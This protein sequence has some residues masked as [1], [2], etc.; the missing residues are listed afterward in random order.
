MADAKKGCGGGCGV[1]PETA[2]A[3]KRDAQSHQQSAT[4]RAPEQPTA[5]GAHGRTL[6]IN[7]GP[8][9]SAECE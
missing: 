3:A 1:G 9:C 8:G 6:L 5:E 7:P 4:H 2:D